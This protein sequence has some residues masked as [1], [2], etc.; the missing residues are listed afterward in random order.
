LVAVLIVG[1]GTVDIDEFKLDVPLHKA[2]F[3]RS[4][5]VL[6]VGAA[7]VPFSLAGAPFHLTPVV[8]STLL[9]LA[10]N[11]LLICGAIYFEKG[12]PPR[13]A[14]GLLIPRPVRGFVVSYAL[15]TGLGVA[16]AL[17]Y[18]IDKRGWAVAAILIPLLFARF[19]IQGAR[20]QQ[21]LS[22]RLQL[23]QQALLEATEKLF[24][25][26]EDERKRVAAQIHDSSLQSLAAASYASGNALDFLKQGKQDA[27]VQAMETAKVAVT[28]AIGELRESLVELRG[29]AWEK[30]T[31]GASIDAFADRMSTLWGVDVAIEHS[32]RAQPPIPVAQAAY[33]I[34][35]EAVTNA[36]KHSEGKQVAVRVTDDDGMVRVIVQDHG[37]GFDPEARIGEDHVG[38]RLMRER[39]A[40]VGG[41]ILIDSAPGRGTRLEAVIPG[42]AA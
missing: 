17:A 13:E 42:G 23:Q 19:G 20:A 16:T 33:Q 3:N 22:E 35:Q 40:Q 41:R 37:E 9:T 27:A 18:G 11:I 30:G 6:S 7:V 12:I 24:H 5:A 39:A 31:L 28:G 36:L 14:V 25:E 29:S 26:R 2:L 10:T 32:L 4:M 34:L 15:L 1:L 38:M 8:A 21:E